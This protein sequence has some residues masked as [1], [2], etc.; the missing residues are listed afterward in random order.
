VLR[1]STESYT[2]YH[3][4]PSV[5]AQF[6]RVCPGVE[7]QVKADLSTDPLDGLRSGALDL[8]IVHRTIADASLR[9]FPLFEDEVVIVVSAD[10]ALAER[11][12]VEPSALASEHLLVYPI[13]RE[14]NAVFTEILIPGGVIPAAIS[15]VPLTELMLEMVHA[16]LGVAVLS[17]WACAPA[18]D[19]GDV[20]AIRIGRAGTYRSWYAAHR[21]EASTPTY[22]HTLIELLFRQ[23]IRV[24]ARAKN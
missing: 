6:Q 21:D 13:P 19:R 18:V 1:V 8:A 15:P 5:L 2:S 7:V 12:F 22:T 11:T 4:L 17:R 23:P 16:G 3:W 24:R 14:R 20:R 9:F 10:H